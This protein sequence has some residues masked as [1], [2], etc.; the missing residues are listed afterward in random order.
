MSSPT[1]EPIDDADAGAA[2][3]AT[4]GP[5]YA[6]VLVDI[7][8]D[9]LD[10]LF[11][12]AVPDDLGSAVQ[13]GSRVEVVFGGRRVRGLV[14]ELTDRT[15]LDASRIRALR[16]VLG[17]HAWLTSA[18]IELV[19]WAGQRFA[20]PAA[21]LL[22][23]VL[24][25]RVVA[26]E[27]A[28]E[29]AGWFPPGTAERPEVHELTPG[30]RDAWGAYGPSG[31]ELLDA[32][33]GARDPIA[34]YWRPLPAEDLGARLV[35]LAGA[36][37]ASGR[38]VHL[39]T[40][41]PTSAAA[42]AVV[43]AFRGVTVDVRGQPKQRRTYRAWLE[44][45]CGHARVVVGE[46]GT[47]FWP[48]CDPGLFLVLDE[49]SP[50]Y[51]ARRSP[52][53]HVR[54]V[55]LERA[56]RAD[57]TVVLVGEVPSAPAWR[58][59]QQGRLTPVV[60]D[61]ELERDQAP[62]VLVDDRSAGPRTRI[63]TVALDAMRAAVEDG[64]LAVVIASRR[65][66]GTALACTRC[67]RRL[68]C[69]RCAASLASAPGSRAGQVVCAKCSWRSGGRASCN[70]CGGQRFAP[71][72]AGAE[73][74]GEEL[75]RMFQQ[76]PTVVLEGFDRPAPEPP[77][78]VVMTRGSVFRDPPGDVG[79]VVLLD[80]DSMLLRPALDAAED[81]LRLA[82]TAAGWAAGRDGAPAGRVVV[83]TD[84][85]GH[86]AVRAL[87]GWDPGGFWRT[88]AAQRAE[89]GLPPAGYAIRVDAS[90]AAPVEADL[91]HALPPGDEVWGPLVEGGR[92]RFLLKS[93]DR[94]ATVAALAPLRRAWSQA[95]L[96][97]RVDV[98]PVDVL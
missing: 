16:R 5:R 86:H 14:V 57:A 78:V 68:R 77:A 31:V 69:P 70:D 34:A 25:P 75:R 38:D 10:R 32:V 65:G 48:T 9:H 56:R 98:D 85:P 94:V 61:R 76:V 11:D 18:E 92:A 33:G 80:L 39:F 3:R 45:R 83:Q 73:R 91:H 35:E 37:L 27:Q 4:N 50:A 55:A 44:A 8:P 36:T 15:E 23:H 97:V 22:A 71:L 29:E 30:D 1:A 49:S 93:R 72:A 46:L 67:G 53:H 24:P 28:A 12:Y 58:L 2:A 43:A 66:E 40:P 52:Y 89:L 17:P 21:H 7:E 6:R 81:A 41:S 13:V 62:A 54:E 20:S 95:G 59:L 26:V 90:E 19:W 87:V 63:G 47:A 79:A 74:L 64:R 60:P 82:V 96:D 88:E 84:Q 42:D 51:K